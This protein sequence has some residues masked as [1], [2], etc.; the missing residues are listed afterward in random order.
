M[1]SFFSTIFFKIPANKRGYEAAEKQRPEGKWK[2]IL[3]NPE[4]SQKV[5]LMPDSIGS[6]HLAEF[7]T[8]KYSYDLEYFVAV[9]IQP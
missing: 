1:S 9:S 4:D 7:Y 5:A 6:K 2:K 8:A 3:P